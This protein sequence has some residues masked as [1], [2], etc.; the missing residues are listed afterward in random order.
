[1]SLLQICVRGPDWRAGGALCI[2]RWSVWDPPADAE[3]FD[4]LTAAARRECQRCPMLREC[5]E[6]LQELPMY[7]RPMGVTAGVLRRERGERK[8]YRPR[9]S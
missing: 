8:P 9:A 3:V 1:M 4:Y 2:G 5:G 7:A 6:W